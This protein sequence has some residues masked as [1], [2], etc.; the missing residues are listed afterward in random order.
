[1]RSTLLCLVAVC[2][3]AVAGCDEPKEN[4]LATDGASADDIAKYEEE[5]AAV[6]GD[7][8]YEDAEGGD[9]EAE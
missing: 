4:S 6:S 1:M 8:S 9:D 2:A 5:L 7:D 3:L